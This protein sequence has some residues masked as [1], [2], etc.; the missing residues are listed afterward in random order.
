MPTTVLPSEP[1]NSFGAY[2]ASA[3]TVSEPFFLTSP[4]TSAERLADP[5]EAVVVDAVVE[6][7]VLL[8]LLPPQPATAGYS[9][10][11]TWKQCEQCVT[12]THGD[13]RDGEEWPGILI[14]LRMEIA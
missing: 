1:M 10:L 11:S 13:L 7:V 9:F 12:S 6:E 3:A 4:G 5:V 2:V 14:T 8:E